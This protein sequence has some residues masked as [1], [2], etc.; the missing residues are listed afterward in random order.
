[1]S[2]LRVLYKLKSHDARCHLRHDTPW[3][4]YGSYISWNH[5]IALEWHFFPSVK[6]PFSWLLLS[7]SQYYLYILGDV[8]IGM[9]IFQTVAEEKFCILF[10]SEFN[11]GGNELKFQVWVSRFKSFTS[12]SLPVLRYCRHVQG[13]QPLPPT[14][15]LST[16]W[17]HA[18]SPH[19][20]H[21]LETDCIIESLRI[22]SLVWLR[23]VKVIYF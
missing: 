3:V 10:S 2:S 8:N 13:Q 1:M 19:S 15:D 7:D 16:N 22:I 5:T 18:L 21:K 23:I 4:H 20:K 9:N 12:G 11:V 14:T 6:Y 17:Q